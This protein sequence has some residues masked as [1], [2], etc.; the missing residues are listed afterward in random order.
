MAAC[1]TAVPHSLLIVF[2]NA[3]KLAEWKKC[4]ADEDFR[5]KEIRSL[6]AMWYV[7][8][9]LKQ[10]FD[11]LQKQPSRQCWKACTEE[12]FAA[13]Q[14]HTRGCFADYSLK[15][16][17]DGVLLSQQRLE[18]VVSWWPMQCAQVT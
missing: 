9:T 14:Q 11:T 7:A 8:G 4:Q 5:T 12:F 17:L 15:I 13:L 1:T 10:S 3:A 18:T 2:V 6:K 16:A